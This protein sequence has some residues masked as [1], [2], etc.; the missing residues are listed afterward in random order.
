MAEK[1]DSG[2]G[3]HT[4][5]IGA[6]V[7]GVCCGLYLQ[8]YGQRVTIVDPDTPGD[9]A[10][11][12]NAGFISPG[13]CAPVGMPGLMAKVPGMLLDPLGPLFIRWRYL[14]WIAPWLL[15]LVAASTPERVEEIS[16]A[17]RSLYQSAV[18]D[19]QPLI[20]DAKAE[21]LIRHDGRLEIYKSDASLHKDGGKYDL[22]RRRDVNYSV[23][24][25]GELHELEPALSKDYTCAA[26]IP[27][28]VHTTN[29]FNLTLALFEHFRSCGGQFV[30][31]RA[32]GFEMGDGGPSRLITDVGGHE[33]GTVVVAAGAY[34]RSLA[35]QLG[36]KVPL[37][38]ERG[39]HIMLPE[40]GIT[41]N[42]P[43]SAGDHHFAITP[44]DEGIR[45]AGT[46]E[47][48]GLHAPPNYA[49]ADALY[50]SA[51]KM[52]PGLSDDGAERWMGRRPSMPDSIPVISRS[53]KHQSVFF[54]FGHGHLGL[55]G[56]AVTGKLI[57]E[58][59]TGKP[60]NIGLS[61]FRVDRF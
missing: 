47:F 5:I 4:T 58:M 7:V 33:L 46:D 32:M 16:Q 8:R 51:L 49:R 57:A 45:L 34:S 23:I 50:T 22:M 10:S 28:S 18:E 27:E 29:P 15:R 3:P 41:L 30:Q 19:F 2:S 14:P 11:F 54:A 12:G 53:P 43:I 55:T 17:M 42:H 9:G 20:R 21:H 48:A 24:G 59:V 1:S 52:F 31:E 61:P 26:F 56:A 6:G 35:R 60:H 39:Y 25:S 40:P 44:M 36:S 38:T 13:S 37:D